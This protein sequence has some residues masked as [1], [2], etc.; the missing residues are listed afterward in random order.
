MQE[1]PTHGVDGG[2]EDP[3]YL[4]F[5]VV[6]FRKFTKNVFEIFNSQAIP[7]FKINS[8]RTS[9]SRHF[10][11]FSSSHHDFFIQIWFPTSAPWFIAT[12]RWFI[13]YDILSKIL[14]VFF[15]SPKL[16]RIACPARMDSAS[17]GGFCFVCSAVECDWRLV[18]M[19]VKPWCRY[20]NPWKYRVDRLRCCCLNC[21]FLSLVLSPFY[22]LFFKLNSRKLFLFFFL[23]NFA[24][25]FGL[26][27]T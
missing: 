25:C 11:S 26:A 2:G 24:L 27:I 13:L 23:F 8:Q 21:H 9:F 1:K 3:I 20:Y 6:E 18:S 19:T 7:K 12:F 14:S 22:I 5:S 15:N 4:L 17:A 10:S 16:L